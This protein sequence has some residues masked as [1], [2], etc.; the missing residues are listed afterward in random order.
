MVFIGQ[1]TQNGTYKS[2]QQLRQ[3]VSWYFVPAEFTG[4]SKSNGYS[5]IQMRS[6]DVCG[7]IHPNKHSNGPGKGNHNQASIIALGLVQQYIRYYP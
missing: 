7:N 4:H 1:P 2:A 3:Q 6:T 5:R